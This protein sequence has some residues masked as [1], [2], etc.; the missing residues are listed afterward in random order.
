MAANLGREC[1]GRVAAILTMV[2]LSGSI[3]AGCSTSSSSAS[4]SS[5]S[6]HPFIATSQPPATVPVGPGLFVNSLSRWEDLSSGQRASAEHALEVEEKSDQGSIQT[7][8]RRPHNLLKLKMKASTTASDL[9]IVKASPRSMA[10]LAS[11]QSQNIAF[12]QNDQLPLQSNIPCVTILSVVLCSATIEGYGDGSS[13]LLTLGDT[14]YGVTFNAIVGKGP[15]GAAYQPDALVTTYDVPQNP[16]SDT[17]VVAATLSTW[18]IDVSFSTAL[19][20]GG[21]DVAWINADGPSAENDT[22]SP[23]NLIP[24]LST[25]HADSLF[26]GAD[27]VASIISTLEDGYG[28][29]TADAGTASD[30]NIC[31]GL[32][33]LFSVRNFHKRYDG[34]SFAELVLLP[35][36]ILLDL[37][38]RCSNGHQPGF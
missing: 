33:R 6:V 19:L 9:P 18:S 36:V 23:N 13:N 29:V 30:P 4:K 20:G 21:C 1:P 37:G 5:M 8:E 24:C 11:S 14:T 22:G 15:Y 38:H 27:T 10:R 7:F 26:E 17:A 2:A 35:G 3:V 34:F 28:V 31:R 32:E 25:F 12:Q 16:S